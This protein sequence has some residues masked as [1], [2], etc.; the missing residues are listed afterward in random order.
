MADD[1]TL[2]S[3]LA[4]SGPLRPEWAVSLVQQIAAQVDAANAAQAAH[5][6]I[7]P[8]NIVLTGDGRAYLAAADPGG[9]EMPVTAD[10]FAYLAPERITENDTG[11]AADVYALACVL[12]TALAGAPPYPPAAGVASL[13]TAHLSAPI[14]HLPSALA[15]FDAVVARGLAKEPRDRYR[16]TGELAAA[17]EYALTAPEPSPVAA[18]PSPG[19]YE[20]PPPR[21]Y[22][23]PIAPVAY[24]PT[25]VGRPRRR[26]FLLLLLVP[27]V[28]FTI[29]LVIV[30]L[31]AFVAVTPSATP[32][33]WASQQTELPFT[34]LHDPHAL[35]VDKDGN[36][37]VTDIDRPD[38]FYSDNNDARVLKLAPGASGPTRLPFPRL[39]WPSGVAVD[40]AGNVYVADAVAQT[41]LK[42][43]PGAATPTVLPF[44]GLRRPQAVAVDGGGNVY[45]TDTSAD[46]VLKLAPG[47]SDPTELPF[48]DLAEPKGVAVD[49]AGNVYVTDWDKNKVL[50]LS[51]E[52]TGATELPVAGGPSMPKGVAL[53]AHGNLYVITLDGLVRI[54]PDSS[55]STALTQDSLSLAGVAVD[56]AGTVYVLKK[57]S[58]TGQ[59]LKLTAS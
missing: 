9:I 8:A 22:P 25:P 39:D 28:V 30:G 24:P 6:N 52:D 48:G 56:S 23:Q 20:A 50:K 31:V 53:D 49:A 4:R 19:P 43:A 29:V 26:L 59:V 2:Q 13:I 37:Y 41:V 5:R 21:P 57:H 46:K 18:A 33:D 45:V 58:N 14:P 27:S 3:A 11:P 15:G 38:D 16:S 12:Y 44:P 47:A 32:P 10:D 51:P 54:A 34:D 17:A 1:T 55:T 42:L 40:A 36:V 7:N 35:A